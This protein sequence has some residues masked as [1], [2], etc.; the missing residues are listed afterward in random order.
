MSARLQDGIW[1]CKEKQKSNIVM[2]RI[3]TSGLLLRLLSFTIT[4]IDNNRF[5]SI[6]DINTGL[7]R[8]ISDIDFYRFTTSGFTAHV[9][10]CERFE[11]RSHFKR[12]SLIVRVNVVLNRTVVVDSD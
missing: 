6:S 9:Y 12:L 7:N 4:K 11:L 10:S 1:T 2:F 3:F 8:L 5:L